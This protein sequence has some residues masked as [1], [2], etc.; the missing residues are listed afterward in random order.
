MS[1]ISRVLE[2]KKKIQ[3]LKNNL[4]SSKDELKRIQTS[5]K[6]SWG[7]TIYDPIVEEPYTIP[8][9]PPGTM[10]SDWRGST[11]VPRKEISRWKRTCLD[12]DLTECTERVNEQVSKTPKF[13]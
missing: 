8:A 7:Q 3:E 5:C 13:D 2:L 1:E 10:G 4:K 9:D 11:Y 12:C 6:H